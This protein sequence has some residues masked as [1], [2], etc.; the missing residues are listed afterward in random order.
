MLPHV[1]MEH[2][3]D[4]SPLQKCPVPIVVGEASSRDLTGSFQIQNP[5]AGTQIDMVF[6]G[7]I[8]VRNLS[9]FPDHDIGRFIGPHRNTLVGKIRDFGLEV[10]NT[11]LQGFN[12]FIQ[13]L[14]A[15][16]DLF[17]LL[18]L[19]AGIHSLLL[20]LGNLVTSL[21]AKRAGLL[22]LLSNRPLIL[23]QLEEGLSVQLKGLALEPLL[24]G[25]EILSNHASI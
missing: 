9:D 6:D 15:S 4:Q 14:D 19:L 1:D 12:L 16:G 11:F 13:L 5:Q 18:D 20:H 22:P 2:E 24:H 3:I 23:V 17:H 25:I 10:S 21:I 7:E 8:K